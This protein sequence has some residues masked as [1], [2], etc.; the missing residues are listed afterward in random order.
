MGWGGGHSVMFVFARLLLD[1]GFQWSVV[2]GGG[3]GLAILAKG[4]RTPLLPRGW[5]RQVMFGGVGGGG[6]TLQTKQLSTHT[7][8]YTH[9]AHTCT[10]HGEALAFCFFCAIKHSVQS[11]SVQQTIHVANLRQR[12]AL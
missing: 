7:A 3:G 8:T 5:S 6:A 12:R 4:Q 9:T 2:R 10:M 1:N 11:P